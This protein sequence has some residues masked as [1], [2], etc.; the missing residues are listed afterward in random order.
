MTIPTLS[1]PKLIAGG[2]GI[3]ALLL[4][5]AWVRG[6]YSE[7]NGLRAWR[8]DLVTVVRAEVPVDRRKSVSAKTAADEIRWLGREYR[9]HSDALRIQSERLVIA[10][11]RTEGAQNAAAEAARRAVESDRARKAVRDR[12]TDPARTGGLTQDEWNQL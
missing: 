7:R 1:T 2:V 5:V 11:Q 6:L 12:L 8:D 10:K 9:T 4:F 3:L